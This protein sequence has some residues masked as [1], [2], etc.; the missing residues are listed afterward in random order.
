M[1][2]TKLFGWA[3]VASMMSLSACSNDAEEVLTQESEIKLTS[4]ITPSRAASNLQ[5]E[6]IEEGQQI[7]VTITGSKS[8]DNY[9][10]KLWTTDGEGGLSTEHI[11]YWAN[12]NVDITAY[13]P[14]N[15]AWTSGTPTFTVNTDQSDED[16]YLNSDLL[17]ASRT[18]VAK[19]ENGVSL[20]FAHKLAKINVNLQPEYPEMDLTNAVISICNTKTSTTF[21]L[22]DGSVPTTATGTIQEIKAGTGL[23]ASA[24][25]VPQT[26]A[27]GSKFIKVVLGEK[28]FYYS[29]PNPKTLISGYSHNY[30]LTVKETALQI[31]NSS[32]ITDWTDDNGNIGDANEADDTPYLTFSANE[33][34]TL[35][36]TKAIETLE[37]SIDGGSWTTLGTTT[38][39]FGGYR[40]NLRLRGKS[41]IGTAVNTDDY[42]RIMFGN[43]ANVSCSGD[44]R[45]LVDYENHSTAN[46]ENARFCS[47]FEHCKFLTSAPSLPA[48]TLAAC[49]YFYMFQHCINLIEAPALPA[50]TL[51]NSCYEGMF[52]SCDKLTNPPLLPATT[53]AGQCY[54]N[55]F[56]FCESLQTPPSLPAKTIDLACYEFM[57]SG[58]SSL[59]QAPELPATT[60]QHW[61][62]RSMFKDCTSLTVSPKLTATTLVTSCYE[63]MFTGCSNLGEVTM[64]ATNISAENCLT[65]WLDGVAL[66]GSF[67]KAST[68][69]SLT[70]GISGIPNNW[71]IQNYGE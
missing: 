42:A 54:R 67:I 34:Q 19:N 70:Q 44:I 62:Y 8:G 17:F 36:M 30:T 9:V 20:T 71:K 37:Y 68:M 48:T 11:V 25:V 53:L 39:T 29:L 1:K 46:T 21:N 49:C 52:L 4:E 58:C 27:S 26:I 43:N 45:T 10:N 65:N 56:A 51:A 40:G 41:S 38:V 6:Q 5:S 14:Y 23:T 63:N 28:T 59:T 32:E 13:H 12:T 31:V 18:D 3:L 66:S 60:L 2:K 57:F 7:G 64:L 55:M 15:E 69:N 22:S 24:I 33:E 50:I 35:T 61:C 16:N 47:L